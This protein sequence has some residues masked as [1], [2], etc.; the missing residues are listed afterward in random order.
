MQY[1]EKRRIVMHTFE[2]TWDQIFTRFRR[3]MPASAAEFA[4]EEVYRR[5]ATQLNETTRDGAAVIALLDIIVKDMLPPL[6]VPPV[7]SCIVPRTTNTV[8]QSA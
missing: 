5:L 6:P 1:R 3:R 2:E 7:Q 8:R 4:A